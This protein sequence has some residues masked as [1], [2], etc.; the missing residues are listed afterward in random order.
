MIAGG[1]QAAVMAMFRYFNEY[2][3]KMRFDTRGSII[4]IV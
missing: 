1:I 4:M 2:R 3:E